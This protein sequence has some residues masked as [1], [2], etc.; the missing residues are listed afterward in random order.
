[1]MGLSHLSALGEGGDNSE[2]FTPDLDGPSRSRLA[3]NVW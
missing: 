3:E 1:V 2:A